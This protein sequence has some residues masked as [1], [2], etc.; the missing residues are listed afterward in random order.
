MADASEAAREEL[1]TKCRESTYFLAKAV[2]GFD[3]VSQGTHHPL[4]D[5]LD[6]CPRR[7]LVLAPRS[8]YKSTLGTITDIVR[9]ILRNPD[10]RI[11]LVSISQDNAKNMLSTVKAQFERNATLRWLFPELLPDFRTVRW[12]ETEMEVKRERA[13][14]EPTVQAIGTSSTVVSRHYDIIKNDDLVDDKTKDSPTEL[15]RALEFYKLEESLLVNPFEGVIHTI[16]TR[17]GFNDPYQWMLTKETGLEQFV[18]GPVNDDGT[19]Y[20]PEQLP[21]DELDRL[22]QKYGSYLF[23]C[24][25]ENA[26]KDPDA[27]SFRPSWLRR[28][29]L[30]GDQII[31]AV[32][33]PIPLVACRRYMRVDP[34]ISER[35][36][37]ARTG[38]IVDAVAP[39]GRKFLLETWAKR[40]QPSEM[41]E[42]I[43]ALQ[44]RWDCEA[45]G[46]EAVAYQRAIKPFLEAEASRRGRW[47]NVVELRP[48]TRKSKEARIRS[49]QPYL[50]RGEVSVSDEHEQF[51]QEYTEFPF[52]STVDLLDAWAYGPVMWELPL[53]E[54]EDDSLGEEHWWDTQQG[55]RSL[56]TGY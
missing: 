28:H 4:C 22:K 6:A 39:D 47:L 26:P 8:T 7:A 31:P 35:T 49:V 55:G 42:A 24:L 34:A 50:E 48:D 21:Q 56:A 33:Q 20:F 23:A 3:K 52:G 13:W 43:F 9:H 54:P 14:P 16:G 45:I 40:C 5:F 29:K 36:T 51:L 30:E 10:V 1:R 27:G 46:I 12:N 2:L 53:D 37:A 44:G 41:F 17:W 25:Y 11:L 38:I 15:A 32:G 19:L 18:R